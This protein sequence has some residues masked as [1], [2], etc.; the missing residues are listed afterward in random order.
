MSFLRSPSPI[1]H[2]PFIFCPVTPGP[3]GYN[4]TADP[5]TPYWFVGNT[6]GPLGYNDAADPDSPRSFMG[7][8]HEPEKNIPRGDVVH[9]PEKLEVKDKRGIPFKPGELEPETSRA[10]EKLYRLYRV[11][12]F[13]I[14]SAD[15]NKP[16]IAEG[17]DRLINHLEDLQN[18]LEAVSISLDI[19]GLAS[20]S[21]VQYPNWAYLKGKE[22]PNPWGLGWKRA[23]AI[24]EYFRESNVSA[25]I[26]SQTFGLLG[27]LAPDVKWFGP[28][29]PRD[30]PSEIKARWRAATILVSVTASRPTAFEGLRQAEL[31]QLGLP[32]LPGEATAVDT[33]LKAADGFTLTYDLGGLV[34]VWPQILE[35]VGP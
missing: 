12:G 30:A 22:I 34:G 24:K 6:P 17:L 21:R 11:V 19:T 5:D 8:E 9:L 25:S 2:D 7:A 33:A 4:D 1:G 35:V 14:G 28:T 26:H 23:E 10:I 20:E 32:P 13:D 29:P 16:G 27:G 15:V 31:Q 3:L 18:D